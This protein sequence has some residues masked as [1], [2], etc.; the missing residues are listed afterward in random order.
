MADPSPDEKNPGVK[1]IAFVV[2]SEA[3]STGLDVFL[4]RAI[5]GSKIF[6]D[7]LYGD[8]QFYFSAK[9]AHIGESDAKKLVLYGFVRQVRKACFAMFQKVDLL[10]DENVEDDHETRM[11]LEAIC[12][13]QRLWIRKL[14]EILVD[15]INFTTTDQGPAYRA[16]LS[17]ENLELFEG[18]Q[19]DFNTF[20]SIKSLNVQSSVDGFK[21]RVTDD[22]TTI[23]RPQI[24]FINQQRVDQSRLPFFSSA[25]QRFIKALSHADADENVI[26]GSTYHSVYSM[27]SLSMHGSAGSHPIDIDFGFLRANAFMIIMLSSHILDRANQLMKFPSEHGVKAIL[28]KGSDAPKILNNSKKDFKPGD[29]VLASGDL[30]EVIEKFDG[31]YGYTAYKVKYLSKPPI[32]D[33]LE[34][35]YPSENIRLLFSK[36]RIRD[37]YQR[38]IANTTYIKDAPKLLEQTDEFL[39]DSMKEMLID[40]ANRGLLLKL[41]QATKESK[42]L[43]PSSA[44]PSE[45]AKAG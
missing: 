3:K 33:I 21:K 2:P 30:A 24:W 1:P 20:F 7:Q 19:Q 6:L 12:D 34:D 39:Y 18:K 45:P 37:F 35:Y 44:E 13:E 28:A 10:K 31:K 38:A 23:G 15:I 26:L 11:L 41:F 27:T 22:L 4:N 9:Y 36:E 8:D 16:Y 17:L 43:P 42:N 29:L 32:P 40:L 14:S 5:K 25:R